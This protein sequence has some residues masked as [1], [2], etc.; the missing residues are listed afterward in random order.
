[1]VGEWASAAGAIVA[2]MPTTPR[3]RRALETVTTRRPVVRA[4]SHV[5]HRFDAP[6]C[7]LM[8]GRSPW[9]WGYPFL[10][11]TTTGARSGRPRSAPLLC[12]DLE[13]GTLAVVGSNFGGPRT[14]AWCLNLRADPG[15]TVLR[16]GRSWPATAREPQ[17]AERDAI[18]AAATA[19]YA[20]YA[21]YR[22]WT[23]GRELPLFVLSRDGPA[24]PR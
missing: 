22:A 6:L 5:L 20:G 18:W 13:D 2:P 14:P 21:H 10:L 9:G 1:M 12:V 16:D 24:S 7:R 8:S 19:S 4:L 17:G 23:G 3:W 15:C 11:L